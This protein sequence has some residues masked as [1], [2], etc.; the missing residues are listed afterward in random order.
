MLVLT[1]VHAGFR[2]EDVSD[3]ES[4]YKKS[5]S[6]GFGKEVQRRIMLGTF[7]LS[8]GY[9]DAYFG[10][11]QAVRRMVKNWTDKTLTEFD[12]LLCPTTPSTAF[13][14]GR[15]VNDP[16]VN[17]LEDIFTVQANI[18]GTPAVSIPIGVDSGGLPIG[19]QVM[20]A[21]GSDMDTLAMAEWIQKQ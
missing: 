14:L 3:L 17:Y 2:A 1:G 19:L 21:N 15:E 20:G 7:V 13:G 5:R 4:V 11:A 16:T 8:A 18:A 12:V 10:K 9:Y 6:A